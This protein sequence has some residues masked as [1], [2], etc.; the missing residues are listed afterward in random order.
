MHL[1][2]DAPIGAFLS[3]GLDSTALV[4]LM[5]RMMPNSGNLKTITLGVKE[6]INTKNDE[7]KIAA[8]TAKRLGT[9]HVEKLLKY[10]EYNK[11]IEKFIKSMDMPTIDGLN[12][13]FVSKVAAQQG[14]KVVI[15]GLGGDELLG[16]YSSFTE[17]PK[18]YNF[19]KYASK[20]TNFGTKFR[21]ITDKIIKNYTSTKYSG[22]FE[23][24]GSYG[25]VYMLRRGLYMPW[26]LPGIMDPDIAVQGWRE[27]NLINKLNADIERISN[28]DLKIAALESGWYMKNQLLRD[29]DWAG[30]TNSIEIRVPLVDFEMLKNLTP[31]LSTLIKIGKKE[32]IKNSVPDILKSII[33]KS[34]TGF[35]IPIKEW[36]QKAFN[37][38]YSERGL[39][40][41]A[42]NI[43]KYGDWKA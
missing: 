29:A 14:L 9:N 22:M 30:M 27:L 6:Y 25:G 13:Y 2:S 15:S 43:Y 32:V 39:R 23:Y 19:T 36:N 20:I 11:E 31:A 16:G 34:K 24:G 37:M 7:T 42:K 41:W 21:I 8:K 17:I 5:A 26:E 28:S 35:S 18:V 1:I 33:N 3:A 10:E 40:S 4:T 12:T 38:E